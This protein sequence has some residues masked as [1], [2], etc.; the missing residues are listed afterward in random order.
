MRKDGTPLANARVVARSAET[1]KSAFGETDG[2]GRFELGGEIE[3]DGIPPGDYY[4]TIIEDTGDENQRRPATIAAKYRNADSSGLRLS[5]KAGESS[6]LNAT[7][8]P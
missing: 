3:G 4:V 5:V 8:D 7:L 2:Q 6:E 1:G